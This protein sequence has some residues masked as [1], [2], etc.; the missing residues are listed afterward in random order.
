MGNNMIPRTKLYLETTVFNYYFDADRN[1]HP[2]SIALFEAIGRGEYEGY[3][4]TYVIQELTNA[5][6]PKRS[7]MLGLIEKYGIKTFEE[8][9]DVLL[10]A[11]NY[12]QNNIIPAKKQLDAQHIAIASIKNMDYIV[13][14]NFKHINKIKTQIK[15]NAVNALYGYKSNVIICSPMEVSDY[16]TEN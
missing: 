8:T 12:I 15:A 1:M 9:P 5:S 14:L 7:N 11:G 13:S 10:L 6:E 4:S 3:T 16:E 2:A